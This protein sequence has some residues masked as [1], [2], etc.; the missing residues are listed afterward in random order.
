MC[1]TH[2]LKYLYKTDIFIALFSEK[3]IAFR[4]QLTFYD[5]NIIFYALRYISH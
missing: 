5:G 2:V 3:N 4:I 1:L